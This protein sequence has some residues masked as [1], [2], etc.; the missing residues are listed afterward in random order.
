M[1]Q[2]QERCI[3][4]HT[5]AGGFRQ[6]PGVQ[7]QAVAEI[8]RTSGETMLR[9]KS[10]FFKA[11]LKSQVMTTLQRISQRSGNPEFFSRHGVAP[12]EKAL[13]GARCSEDRERGNL[14]AAGLRQRCQITADQ[15]Y[16]VCCGF[17]GNSSGE[18]SSW[19]FPG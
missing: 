16:S 12:E 11:R 10:A 17:P 6:A 18:K 15:Q 7:Q 9:Q 13:M 14:A 5:D 4:F 1:V 2:R 3:D 8:K 19:G